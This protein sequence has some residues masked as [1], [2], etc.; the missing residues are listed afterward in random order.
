MRM[1]DNEPTDPE[2]NLENHR[3]G[4]PRRPAT[5]THSTHTDK[6]EVASTTLS[7]TEP[8]AVAPPRAA[9]LPNVAALPLPRATPRSSLLS[10][11]VWRAPPCAHTQLATSAPCTHTA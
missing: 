4:L 6:R 8:R 9:R 5:H 11:R 7:A 3:L 10:S 2:K 1:G